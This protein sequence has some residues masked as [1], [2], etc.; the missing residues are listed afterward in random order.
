VEH[1]PQQSD[2]DPGSEPTHAAPDKSG[3]G[4]IP[5]LVIL[6]VGAGG[7]SF[8]GIFAKLATESGYLGPLTTAF[9][10][11]ALATPLFMIAL[12]IL[13]AR[14]PRPL[15]RGMI[16]P[17]WLLLPGFLFAGDMAFFHTAFAHTTVSN[18]TLLANLQVF[19]VGFVAWW[20]LKERFR[21]VFLAGLIV[22]FIGIW[23]LLANDEAT[24]YAKNP[25]LG[26]MFAIGTAFWYAA[27]F[28]VVKWLRRS[29]RAIE[30]LTISTMMA[31]IIMFIAVVMIPQEKN[32]LVPYFNE[33][34]P[35][36]YFK[37]WTY[38]L[39]LALVPQC[40]GQGCIVWALSRLPAS[41]SAVVLLLQPVFAAFLGWILL[42]ELLNSWQIAGSIVVL[43][44]ILL[45]KLGTR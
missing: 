36:E 37:A 35:Q 26:N 6:I 20:L 24:H 5:A 10:R 22:A 16:N 39:L 4:S 42:A 13:P 43:V 33:S 21:P 27:Y 31:T 34:M 40:I 11:F 17:L 12:F 30:I 18:G 44:G 45:A 3:A 14:K 15:E 7:I 29:F 1:A 25:M 38:L 2:A 32:H 19:I 23:L 41:F 28:L 9:W 8:A